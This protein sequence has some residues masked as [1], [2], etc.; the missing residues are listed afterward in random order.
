VLDPN[1][2]LTGPEHN[3]QRTDLAPNHLVY[4]IYTSGSTGTPKGVMV[5]HRHLN[6][7]IHWHLRDFSV[8]AGTRS[9]ATAGL[10]FDASAWELWPAL[11]S[12]GTLLLPPRAV[13][14]DIA[15]MLEWWAR[16]PLDISFLVT[17]LAAMVLREQAIGR[18]LRCLLIGGDHLDRMP[19]VLP[20]NLSLINNYGPTETTIVATLWRPSRRRFPPVREIPRLRKH[21]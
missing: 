21:R 5:E 9:T 4:I 6:N 10:A 20:E 3:P 2:P 19:S 15:Q 14:R 16:Q 1:L 11:S 13:A 12:G 8:R 18:T 7:L 17:P